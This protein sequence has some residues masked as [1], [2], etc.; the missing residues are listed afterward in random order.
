M[1]KSGRKWPDLA[2]KWEKWPKVGKSGLGGGVWSWEGGSGSGQGG[3]E[4]VPGGVKTGPR[5]S[6]PSPRKTSKNFPSFGSR[7]R[8]SGNRPKSDYDRYPGLI[9]KV[10]EYNLSHPHRICANS[11]P[12][13]KSGPPPGRP[14]FLNWD[15]P[16]QNGPKSQDLARSG[17]KVGNLAKSGQIWPKSREIWPNLDPQNREI[18]PKVGKS[19]KSREIGQNPG[20]RPKSGKLAK[21]LGFRVFS[22][23]TFPQIPQNTK[24]VARIVEKWPEKSPETQEKWPE[25]LENTKFWP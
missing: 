10:T 19:A 4:S 3:P 13:G 18:W 8:R 6:G 11:G 24:K 22:L 5:K 14:E 25:T 16:G 23:N 7:G 1:A 12:P 2:Q 9:L 17:P 20:N 21:I 15:P